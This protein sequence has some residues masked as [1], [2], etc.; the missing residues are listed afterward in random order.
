VAWQKQQRIELLRTIAIVTASVNPDKAQQALSRLI[1]EMFP[2]HKIEREKSVERAL[3]IMEAEKQK[4]YTVA[5]VG[6]S[7][8]KNTPAQRIQSILDKRR[9]RMRQ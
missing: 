7:L 5:A 4:T 2:E 3:E 9:R 6:S 1:E 8:S